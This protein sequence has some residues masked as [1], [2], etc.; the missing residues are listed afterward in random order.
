MNINNQL[1]NV[2]NEL[3]FSWVFLELTENK[4]FFFSTASMWPHMG[5]QSDMCKCYTISVKEFPDSAYTTW[6]CQYFMHF[7]YTPSRNIIFLVFGTHGTFER[8]STNTFSMCGSEFV[9]LSFN[10]HCFRWVFFIQKLW[11]KAIF[12][13]RKKIFSKQSRLFV[14]NAPF[15]VSWFQSM[16]LWWNAKIH[17]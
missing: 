10:S 17:R 11:T 6:Y 5:Y 13:L 1:E 9:I 4:V 14:L 8:L 15:N 16:L 12:K 2:Y 7:R 3:K